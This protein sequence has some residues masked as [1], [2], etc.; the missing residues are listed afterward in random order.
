MLYQHT[1]GGV[2]CI[3]TDSLVFGLTEHVVPRRTKEGNTAMS[4]TRVL[5]GNQKG[6]AGKTTTT[7]NLASALSEL[8]FRVL[9]LDLDDRRGRISSPNMGRI[10]VKTLD[11]AD[12]VSL[13]E[14]VIETPYENIS[15][16]PGSHELNDAISKIAQ[17]PSRGL[18]V[19][20][21]ILSDE[22]LAAENLAFDFIIMDTAPR[23]DGLLDA[24]L[25]AADFVLPVLAP[26]AM[27]IEAMTPFVGRIDGARGD[28][29]PSVRT[30][31]ALINK[32]NLGWTLSRNVGDVLQTL[33]IEAFP[34][35][36]PMYSKIARTT[37]FGPIL[38]SDGNS[39]EAGVVRGAMRQVIESLMAAEVK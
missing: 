14:A 2:R 36:I 37:E 4:C 33:G 3:R 35:A 15:V 1:T 20:R 39:R 6:G 25:T 26:E 10:I 38:L 30:L 21:R 8:G 34:G 13:A 7:V 27:Q 12:Q 5:V 18:Y 28:S 19:L 9:V 23:L 17:H 11:E 24:A 31:P 29:N 22:A 16:I 32:A